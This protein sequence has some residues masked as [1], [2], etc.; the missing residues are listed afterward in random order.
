MRGEFGSRALFS[1]LT[2]PIYLNHA[3]VSPPSDPVRAAADAALTDMQRFGVG[4]IFPWIERRELLRGQVAKLLNAQPADIGFPPG[5][6]RG[7]VDL[8]LAIPWKAGDRIV[9]FD[10]EFPSNVLPW[11]TVAARFDLELVRL[12][13]GDDGGLT[14]LAAAL[15]EGARL[16]AVSAVQFA[17]GLAMPIEAI[18]ELAHDA[19]AE[20]LVDAVQAVGAMPIHT[21]HGFDY[22]VAGTHKWLM[23]IDGLALAYASPQAR[24]RLVPLTAG[25]LSTENAVDFLFGPQDL[26]RYDRPLRRS[27]DWMEG[28]VQTTAAFAALAASLDI[29]HELTP[30][31]IFAHIQR[32]HDLAEP[33]LIERGFR[34]A[35]TSATAGRSGILSLRPPAGVDVAALSAALLERGVGVSTPDGWLRMSP[36]WPNH[37]DQVAPMLRAVDEALG[38]LGRR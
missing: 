14:A 7:I 37:T 5:T 31:A 22:L 38:A 23:G 13:I 29:L 12:P 32:W 24:E 10:T 33:E 21:G 20:V 6:T 28:G 9:V 15:T 2:V 11:Q 26:L 35:R 25:W 8:A 16:V 18:A 4:A 27:L 17:T 3:A 36:H 1:Q 30:S 34:S 19:G